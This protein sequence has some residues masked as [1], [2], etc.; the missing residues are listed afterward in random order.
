MPPNSRAWIPPGPGR[1]PRGKGPGRRR[2]IPAV[3]DARI[4]RRHGHLARSPPPPGPPKFPKPRP[5]RP[6]VPHPARR[7]HGRP[8]ATHRRARRRHHPPLGD[9]CPRD[10]PG[11]PRRPPCLAGQGRR[12]RRLPRTVRSRPS[13]DPIGPEPATGNPDLRAAWHE[14]RAALTLDD[15]GDIRH[16]TDGQLLNLQEARPDD[17]RVP[18]PAVRQAPPGP[19][20]RPRREPGSAT[21]PRR[22]QRRPPPRRARRGGR[23]G[24]AGR[25]LPGNARCLP[26]TRD[27]T[28]HRDTRPTGNNRAAKRACGSAW[29]RQPPTPSSAIATR[30]RP[31][32]SLPTAE[33]Q[34][35]PRARAESRPQHEI[36]IH[37][38]HSRGHDHD[39]QPLAPGDCPGGDLPPGSRKPPSGTAISLPGSPTPTG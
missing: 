10:A 21:R 26:R 7:R 33:A 34:P 17:A 39:S 24:N 23:A 11:R 19:R 5:R 36:P 2:D 6:P 18:L 25:E 9:R 4:R 8:P 3:I 20:R 31:R 38:G 16:L 28:R 27:R 14:A 22:S 29:P 32:P 15:A 13:D 12:D 37:S 35:A 1:G 30:A